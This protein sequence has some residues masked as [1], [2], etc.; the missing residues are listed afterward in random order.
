MPANSLPDP[1]LVLLYLCITNSD[2]TKIDF[3]AVG[4]AV[5]LKASA[6]RMRWQR[7][8]NKIESGFPDGRVTMS[9]G[10]GEAN[11]DADFNEDQGQQD[12][13]VAGDAGP[14]TPS[15]SKKRKVGAAKD[16]GT[17]EKTTQKSTPKGKG[18]GKGK[19]VQAQC[20]VGEAGGEGFCVHV[21]SED[22][23]DQY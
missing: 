20:D 3:E 18:K 22:M 10:A 7:L 23:H 15:P 9:A 14:A 13:K 19:V 12:G 8:K 17:H 11:A 6:A 5:G 1:A 21:K 2:M 16:K 4:A